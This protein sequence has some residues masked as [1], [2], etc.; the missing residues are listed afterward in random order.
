MKNNARRSNN[1]SDYN[2]YRGGRIGCRIRTLDSS[3][4][5]P[6]DH[7][8]NNVMKRYNTEGNN[9]FS[10]RTKKFQLKK[11]KIILPNT[12]EKENA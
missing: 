4:K 7:N 6:L 1:E 9:R 2:I 3:D 5:S 12:I 10:K 11:N 8:K